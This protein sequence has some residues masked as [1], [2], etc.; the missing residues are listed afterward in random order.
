V[1]AQAF[2]AICRALCAKT[3][4]KAVYLCRLE[5]AEHLSSPLDT[6]LA[7]TQGSNAIIRASPRYNAPAFV[8]VKAALYLMRDPHNRMPQTGHYKYHALPQGFL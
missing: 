4:F 3:A 7:N 5:S 1:I 8:R 2:A 6:A